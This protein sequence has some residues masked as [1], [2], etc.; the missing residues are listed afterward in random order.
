MKLKN[1]L[2]GF[3]NIFLPSL[4]V[5]ADYLFHNKGLI[6]E[7]ELHKEEVEIMEDQ[8]KKELYI[9]RQTYLL[10]TYAD[11]EAYCQELNE[12]LIANNR[13]AERDMM[14]QRNRQ[15][16]TVLISGTIMLGAVV[17]VLFQAALPVESSK[18][19]TDFYSLCVAISIFLLV[20][21]MIICIELLHRI[22]QF[23]YEKSVANVN[24]LQK[25][26]YS[27]ELMDAD[28]SRKIEVQ[29]TGGRADS[30]V[31]EKEKEGN[32]IR[33]IDT[34]AHRRIISPSASRKLVDRDFTDLDA[35]KIDK[36]YQ[37][38]E[39][40]VAKYF[41][42]RDQ[43]NEKLHEIS[44]GSLKNASCER[45]SFGSY[46]QQ[47]CELLN[48]GCIILFYFGTITNVLA[49]LLFMFGYF[50]FHYNEAA[51]GYVLSLLMGCSIVVILI[52][53]GRMRSDS[54]MKVFFDEAEFNKAVASLLE[55]SLAVTEDSELTDAV[56]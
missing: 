20:V 44:G 38:H 24:H 53:V 33:D 10:S 29:V 28:I 43:I 13:E 48:Q 42:R 23:M 54:T 41:Q 37:S 14:D 7:N 2:E 34:Y 12:N 30:A 31:T 51:A 47:D 52:I 40:P 56:V 1:A 36:E 35:E 9:E 3:S 49:T 50:T 5:G 8:H 18:W 39:V 4:S 15:L 22:Y 26:V 6:V 32:D 45:R 19:L 21:S 46:W 25:Q 16:Q 55:E 17:G 11:V 27:T